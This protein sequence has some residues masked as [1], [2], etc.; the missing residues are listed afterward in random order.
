M[1]RLGDRAFTRKRAEGSLHGKAISQTYRQP[2]ARVRFAG[3]PIS[4]R[5]L[6]PCSPY[7]PN[8]TFW[9]HFKQSRAKAAQMFQMVSFAT[10]L[11][12]FRAHGRPETP[13][14]NTQVIQN[15]VLVHILHL[16]PVPRAFR[17]SQQHSIRNSWRP[18]E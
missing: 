7:A 10:V 16:L 2:S 14:V 5:I 13:N 9:Y 11:D 4:I 15:S 17:S 1:Q 3:L 18:I 6:D 12:Q 8:G